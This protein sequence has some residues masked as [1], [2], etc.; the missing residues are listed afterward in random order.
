NDFERPLVI[1]AGSRRQAHAAELDHSTCRCGVGQARSGVSCSWSVSLEGWRTGSGILEGP[2]DV[3]LQS[4]EETVAMGP[5]NRG[6]TAQPAD[7]ETP[8]GL[9]AR[10]NLAATERAGMRGS[11][12]VEDALDTVPLCQGIAP[13][14]MARWRRASLPHP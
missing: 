8:A 13:M 3:G 4:L 6:L 5:H 10:R 9:I 11:A 1:P 2:S 7:G 14:T 12:I